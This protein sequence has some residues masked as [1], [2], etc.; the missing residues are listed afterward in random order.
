MTKPKFE[1]TAS[2][3]WKCRHVGMEFRFHR[4]A[5]AHGEAWACRVYVDGDQFD[6]RARTREAGIAELC[7]IVN[8][9][10]RE[11]EA[12]LRRERMGEDGEQG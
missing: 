10:R 3:G 8:D 1:R 7:E 6:T 12:E 9:R 5:A 11:R 4:L 2:G